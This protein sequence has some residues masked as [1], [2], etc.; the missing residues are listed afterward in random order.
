M[1][2][3]HSA[4]A[5]RT[6]VLRDISI[7]VSMV[8]IILLSEKNGKYQGV[9]ELILGYRKNKT[10]KSVDFSGLILNNYS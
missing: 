9:R 6:D 3:L 10:R 2:K 5:G 1:S 4:S 8:N 7:N